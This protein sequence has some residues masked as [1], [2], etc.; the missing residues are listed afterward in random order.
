MT[1]I[2]EQSWIISQIYE[3]FFDGPIKETNGQLNFRCPFCGDSKKSRSKRRCWYYKTSEGQLS[4]SFY[5]FNCGKTGTGFDLVAQ[6]KGCSVKEVKKQYYLFLKKS[7]GADFKEVLSKPKQLSPNSSKKIVLSGEIEEKSDELNIL[8]SWTEL[9]D[10]CKKYLKSRRVFEAPGFD[11]SQSLY[12]D[13]ET[14]RIVFPWRENGK[15]EYY[16]YRALRKWQSPKYLFPRGLKKRIYGLDKVDEYLPFVCFTEGLLD[17]VWVKNCVA[18]GGIFP[19]A[20]QLNILKEKFFGCD[21]IWF[22]DNYWVDEASKKE[23]LK[24]VKE[25][26]RMKIF[27]WQKGCEFKDINEW[28]C[29][30]GNLK[31]FWDEDFIVKNSMTL[32]QASVMLHFK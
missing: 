1:N 11:K 18:V 26:P 2:E 7:N 13:K 8:S 16:Q 10:D 12:Y 30:D 32:G 4:N 25:Y 23:V 15:I 19:T 17:S 14:D 27:K 28:I 3:N 31:R 6:L 24:R 29:S 22:S 9:T 21:L 5:C 20:E